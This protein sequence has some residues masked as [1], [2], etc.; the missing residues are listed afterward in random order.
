MD[1]HN[2]L[3]GLII[4]HTQVEVNGI[5]REFDGMWGS[6]LTDSTAK[7]KPD[8]EA[9]DITSRLNTLSEILEV[10]TKPLI[11]DADTGGQSEHF[12]FTVRSL[13]RLG[14]SAAIIEDKTG[15]KRIHYLEM[16]LSKAKILL[17]IFLSKLMKQR[18]L[19]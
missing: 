8:I 10:T 4:E 5:P 9:V 1:I 19:R 2:A 18:K 3:S 14:V 17:K 11:F 13:E 6:S 15:L 12:K 7:G 16:M